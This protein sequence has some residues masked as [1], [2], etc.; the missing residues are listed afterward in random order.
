[1]RVRMCE[2][3]SVGV[4]DWG[5]F[6]P[7]ESHHHW[8][9]SVP[10]TLSLLSDPCSLRSTFTRRFWF[11]V[12]AIPEPCCFPGLRSPETRLPIASLRYP[13][14]PL[15]KA[16]FLPTESSASAYGKLRVCLRKLRPSAYGK[17]RLVSRFVLLLVINS[18]F[19]QLNPPVFI[20]TSTH[21][22]E[23]D[24][25]MFSSKK[26]N[27]FSTEERKSWTSWLT[28]GWVN[29]QEMFY[30]VSEQITKEQKSFNSELCC[31]METDTRMVILVD[32][33]P[34]R[35]TSNNQDK[36]A[37]TNMKINV[38][39]FQTYYEWIHT[40]ERFIICIQIGTS[41]KFVPSLK[42]HGSSLFPCCV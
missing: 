21:Y 32:Q 38:F 29:D 14:Q 7:A 34:Q 24:P 23:K 3:V 20:V 1:M 6:A 30:S 19:P 26:L 31:C 5:L 36:L 33:L 12:S 28:W 9:I 4:C 41:S 40:L 27:F 10:V 13:P 16:P 22:M 35:Q 18:L 17:L 25:G 37:S 15:R 39:L 42:V 11:L 2:Q 8:A